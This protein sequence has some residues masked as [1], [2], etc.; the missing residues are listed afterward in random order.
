MYLYKR[1]R[2]ESSAPRFLSNPFH[3]LFFCG[4][5]SLSL[6][7]EG[8]TQY[9]PSGSGT[10]W[11]LSTHSPCWSVYTLTLAFGPSRMGESSGMKTVLLPQ[12]FINTRTS[13]AKTLTV[14]VRINCCIACLD[15]FF[16]PGK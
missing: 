6:T 3:G 8:G 11:L 2:G 15:S 5:G 4:N 13:A 10:W 14:N 1:K 16:Q 9:Q 12:P 7:Y